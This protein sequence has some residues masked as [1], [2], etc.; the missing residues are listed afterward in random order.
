ML[1]SVTKPDPDDHLVAQRLL[2]KAPPEAAPLDPALIDA[3]VAEIA[4]TYGVTMP[5]LPGRP[6]DANNLQADTNAWVHPE[7]SAAPPTAGSGSIG[8][9]GA[10]SNT[11]APP[12][13]NTAPPAAASGDGEY[14]VRAC[15]SDAGDRAPVCG[16][17]KAIA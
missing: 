1:D 14:D 4:K 13:E 10:L 17:K 6:S 15:V 8:G 11:A 7:A 12:A 9:S 2:N 16:T 3:Y 5:D